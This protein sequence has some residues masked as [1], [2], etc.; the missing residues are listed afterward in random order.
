MP[1]KKNVVILVGL[2]AVGVGLAAALLVLGA[3]QE[4]PP[5]TLSGA[6]A[7]LPVYRLEGA[8]AAVAVTQG[9]A[10]G[11]VLEA[12]SFEEGRGVIEATVKGYDR[13]LVDT[14][15]AAG[16]LNASQ[17]LEALQLLVEAPRDYAPFGLAE[18]R[19]TVEVTDEAGGSVTLLIGDASPGNEGVYLRLEGERPIYLV[20]AYSL[21]NYLLSVA[22]YLNRTITPGSA[23]E[24]FYKAILGGTVR[25]ELGQVVVAGGGDEYRMTAPV[26]RDLEETMG[27]ALLSS[28]LG[29]SADSV[30]AVDPT[31]EQLASLGL[32]NPYATVEMSGGWGEFYLSATAPDVGGT[33]YIYR[34]GVPLLYAVQAQQLPWLSLQYIDLM[35]PFAYTPDIDRLDYVEVAEGDALYRFDLTH[36]EEGGLAVS[37]GSTPLDPDNFRRFYVTLI[38]AHLAEHAPEE[39]APQAPALAFVYRYQDGEEHRVEFCPGPARRYY[40]RADDGP[41]FLTQ[42]TYLDRVREDLQRVAAGQRVESYGL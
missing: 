38:S 16:V 4:L 41:F 36:G 17:G 42:S 10:G 19:A 13:Q 34:E 39:P 31:L 32:D 24:G 12:L 30:A 33:V 28:L 7:D 21:D 25:E 6:Q 18:P 11:Y 37:L 5:V 23:G 40:I 2:I 15:R 8:V 27:Y 9:E 14:A 22:A 26:N 20:P 3:R 35:D 1:L 29:L